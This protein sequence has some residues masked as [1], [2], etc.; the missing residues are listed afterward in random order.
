M[1]RPLAPRSRPSPLLHPSRR[2]R[3]APPI[4]DMCVCVSDVVVVVAGVIV[5]GVGGVG[6]VVVVVVVVVAILR[7]MISGP[8]RLCF[9]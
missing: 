7:S 6:G 8:I 9:G 3:S 5:V 1:R 2:S 4:G